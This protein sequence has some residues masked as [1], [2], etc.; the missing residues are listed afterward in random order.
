MFRRFVGEGDV[1]CDPV[2]EARQ[3]FVAEK[4]RREGIT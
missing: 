4:K 3:E 2:V 1:S